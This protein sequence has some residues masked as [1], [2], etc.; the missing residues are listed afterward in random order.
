MIMQ[1]KIS[2]DAFCLH[3]GKEIYYRFKSGG[4]I[5]LYQIITNA[6]RIPDSVRTEQHVNQPGHP[7][8]VTVLT[9]FKVT[10]VKVANTISKETNVISA[11]NVSREMAVNNVPLVSKVMNV[12]NALRSSRENVARI[13][14]MVSKEMSVIPVS[15][16]TMVKHVVSYI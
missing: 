10:G 1:V 3:P 15:L 9:P 16:V 8:D 6:W 2:S 11:L 7:P 14:Q 5:C 13:V 12:N 4:D